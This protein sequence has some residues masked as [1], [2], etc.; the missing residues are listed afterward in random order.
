MAFKWLRPSF[1]RLSYILMNKA[2]CS[3]MSFCQEWAAKSSG[4]DFFSGI[5]SGIARMENSDELS[6]NV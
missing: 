5:S 6:Q 3:P 2:L 1:I 4:Y